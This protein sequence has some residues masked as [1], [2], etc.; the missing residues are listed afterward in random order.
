MAVMIPDSNGG[1]R[2][3]ISLGVQRGVSSLA[4]HGKI[5]LEVVRVSWD[6]VM[7]DYPLSQRGVIHETLFLPVCISFKSIPCGDSFRRL[8]TVDSP[9]PGAHVSEL[10]VFPSLHS[11]CADCLVSRASIVIPHLL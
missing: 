2:L 11:P 1:D 3:V 6:V 10:P 5:F 7:W 9:M 4:A 8:L